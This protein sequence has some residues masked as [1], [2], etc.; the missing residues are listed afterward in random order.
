[1]GKKNPMTAKGGHHAK[2]GR[3]KDKIIRTRTYE[4]ML[5]YLEGYEIFFKQ[6]K[7]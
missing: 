4:Y 7:D 1:M 5:M 3:E 2:S 6:G